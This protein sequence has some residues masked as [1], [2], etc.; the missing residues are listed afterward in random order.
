MP[1]TATPGP[2][3]PASAETPSESRVSEGQVEPF[4]AAG[5]SWTRILGGYQNAVTGGVLLADDGG[6]YVVGTTNLAHQPER[7]GDVYL[8]RTD[9]AGEVL[10][11]RTYGGTGYQSRQAI[12]RAPDGSLLVAGSTSV[13]GSAG[14]DAYLLAVDEGGTELWSKTYGGA[15][16]E[17]TGSIVP[18]ADG[19]YFLGGDIVDPEDVVADASAPGYGGFEGR[20][21]VYLLRVDGE[22]NQVWSRRYQSEDNVLASG[23]ATTSDGGLLVVATVTHYPEP[24]DDMILIKVDGQVDEVWS[25]SWEQA[26]PASHTMLSAILPHPSGGFIIAGGTFIDPAFRILL[27]KNDGGGRMAPW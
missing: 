11:E 14:L 19:G 3:A 20:S 25:R 6:V 24:D 13:S 27:M 16:D 23:G 17:F 2:A 15:L 5:D 4:Q 21:N 22:G 1:P 7:Q 18:A 9:A 10:W 12:T 26:T 8:I